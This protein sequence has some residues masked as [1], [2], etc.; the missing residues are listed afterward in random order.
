MEWTKVKDELPEIGESILACGGVLIEP[1]I[2]S[3][4]VLLGQ[5]FWCWLDGNM[6][7]WEPDDMPT[8]WMPL[9]GGPE[10]NE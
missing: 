2:I 6:C 5:W 7:E 8:H 10:E 9:P 1:R 3:R 4:E